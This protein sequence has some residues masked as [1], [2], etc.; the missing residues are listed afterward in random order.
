M[1]VYIH[2]P[3]RRM[4]MRCEDGTASE[5]T[6]GD[7]GCE[8]HRPTCRDEVDESRL[9]VVMQ[10]MRC[11][12][13]INGGGADRL[14]L[15]R[16]PQRRFHARRM[17]ALHVPAMDDCSVVEDAR[18]VRLRRRSRSSSRRRR[19]RHA[20]CLESVAHSAFRRRFARHWNWKWMGVSRR[21][22]AGWRIDR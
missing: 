11:S 12:I 22:D 4:L 9:M 19:R 3:P 18:R 10:M 17:Y 21:H 5:R 6:L 2:L 1:L 13:R 7:Q 16:P 20:W 8:C 14:L 15:F